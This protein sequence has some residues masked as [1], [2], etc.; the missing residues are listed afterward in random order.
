MNMFIHELKAYRKSTIIW[1]LSLMVI[2]VLFMSMFPSFSRDI[3]D[4]KKL[5]EGFPELD[6][7]STWA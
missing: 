6:K 2:V 3:V 5:L 1:S 7:K 4:F